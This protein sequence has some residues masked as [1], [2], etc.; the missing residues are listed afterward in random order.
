MSQDRKTGDFRPE[1]ETLP[2]EA[3]RAYQGRRLRETLT[4]AWETVPAVRTQLG[5]T[6]LHPQD[7]QGLAEL[8]K[9]TVLKKTEL[10]AAQRQELPF[11]GFCGVRREELRRIY[12]SRTGSDQANISI[13]LRK[14]L[15][16]GPVS[17]LNIRFRG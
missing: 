8:E 6:G 13:A 12:I 7:I 3:R 16:S 1:L 10:I 4:Q 15:K 11:G 5:R 14:E 9:I 17:A 2:V